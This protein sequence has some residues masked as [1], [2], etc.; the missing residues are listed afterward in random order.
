[1]TGLGLTA[2]NAAET[3]DD[4]AKALGKAEPVKTMAVVETAKVTREQC[5]T[6]IPNKDEVKACMLKVQAQNKVE[7]AAKRQILETEKDANEQRLT[8]VEGLKKIVA[9]QE[10]KEAAPQN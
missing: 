3:P 4:T 2:C 7:M 5:I 6:L 1:M 10:G 8:T 9:I